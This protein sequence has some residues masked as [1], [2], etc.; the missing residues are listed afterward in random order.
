MRLKDVFKKSI[1]QTVANTPKSKVKFKF[2]K[3]GMKKPGK[4]KTGFK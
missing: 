4:L 3:T 1:T 2:G